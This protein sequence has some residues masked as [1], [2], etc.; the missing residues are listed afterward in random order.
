[1]ALRGSIHQL[2]EPQ[3]TEQSVGQL[4]VDRFDL[5]AQ[6]ASLSR[7]S[8]LIRMQAPRFD[9]MPKESERSHRAEW[10]STPCRFDGDNAVESRRATSDGVVYGYD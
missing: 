2:R 10:L 9:L 3:M 4:L 1:M 8:P 7:R 5:A 6:A